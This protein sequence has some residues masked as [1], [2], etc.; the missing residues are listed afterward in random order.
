MYAEP[1]SADVANRSELDCCFAAYAPPTVTETKTAF[2]KL[3]DKPIDGMYE[4]VIQ[5]LLV[6]QHFMRYNIKYK[7]DSVSFP[8]DLNTT[9][10][11]GSYLLLTF[12]C[13]DIFLLPSVSLQ[14][15]AGCMHVDSKLNCTN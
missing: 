2:R 1:C 9:I 8:P 3:Y 13:C 10:L 6:Q 14:V 5:E 12:C 15:H 4:P 7:Y 11:T